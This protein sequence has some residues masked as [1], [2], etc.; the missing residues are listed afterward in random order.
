VYRSYEVE[1]FFYQHY[2]PTLL[3]SGGPALPWPVHIDAKP[4]S[5]F[6]FVLED[7][8]VRFPISPGDMGIEEVR[9]C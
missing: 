9:G 2:A 6:T 1:A 5:S 4:P 8:E 7:L 3:R